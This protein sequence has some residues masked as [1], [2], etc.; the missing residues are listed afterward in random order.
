M[1]RFGFQARLLMAFAAAIAI[2]FSLALATWYVISISSREAGRITVTHELLLN[3][4]MTRSYMF[5]AEL[6]TQTYRITG[7]PVHLK[8]RDQAA[9][10]RERALARIRQLIVDDQVLLQFFVSLREL[11]DQRLAI[12][13]QVEKIRQQGGESAATAFIATAPL[14]ETRIKTYQLLDAMEQ[15]QRQILQDRENTYQR[16]RKTLGWIEI[17]LAISFAMVLL[18]AYV[19]LMRQV[20]RMTDTQQ[21]LSA[22]EESLTATMNSIGDA[23][24]VTDMEGMITRFNPVAERLTGWPQLQAR[25]TRFNEVICIVDEHSGQPVAVNL[26]ELMTRGSYAS[27]QSHLRIVSRQGCE[28]PVADCVTLLTNRNGNVIGTVL[29][30]RDVSQLRLNERTLAEKNSHLEQDVQQKALALTEKESHLQHVMAAVPVLI[31]FVGADQRYIYVNHQYRER[32]APHLADLSGMRVDQVLGPDLYEIACPLIDRALAGE[33]VSYDWQPFPGV[34]QAIRYLPRFD[35]QGKVTGYFV[36][37]TDIT[38]RKISEDRIGRLN[39][40]LGERVRE[41]E[42]VSRA[43]RTLSAGNRAMLHARNEQDLL[44]AMCE[45]IV[46]TCGYSTAIVWYRTSGN[47]F[48]LQPEAHCGYLGDHQSL[49]ALGLKLSRRGLGEGITAAAVQ[50]GGSH[51]ARGMQSDPVHAA[52]W[53]QLNKPVCGLACPLI[54]NQQVIGSLT[55]YDVQPDA[56]PQQE[57]GL[58]NELADDLSFGIATLRAGI[59]Q[60]RVQSEM[61]YL[62]RYDKLTGLPNALAF[63][64]AIQTTIERCRADQTCFSAQQL[65]IERLGEINEVLGYANGDLIL[66]EFAQRLRELAPPPAF[67]A[68]LRG[69]EFGVLR[70]VSDTDHALS[71]AEKMMQDLRKPYPVADITID[72]GAKTGVAVFPLHGNS[73]DELLRRTGKA[74]YRAR[75]YGHEVD[76]YRESSQQDQLERLNMAGELRRAIDS[77]QLRF[78]LQPKIDMKTGAVAG[79]EALMRWLHPRRGLVPPGQFIGLAEQ[80]GL[81]KPLTEWLIVAVLDMLKAWQEKGLMIPVAINLSAR[82]FRDQQLL[83]KIRRWNDERQVQRGLLEVE[84]TESTVMDDPEY[85]MQVLRSLKSDG[86]PLYVDDFGTGYSSLSYLQKLP[87]DYIKIDQSFVAAMLSNRDSAI[88]VKS[89]I[90][91]IHDLGHKTIAEGVE[92]IEHWDRLAALGC[93]Y[94][95][96]YLIARPMPVDEFPGWLADYRPQQWFAASEQAG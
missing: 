57:V 63:A 68:R 30:F 39:H 42:L 64:E 45:T 93:D 23:V 86:I 24:V 36:L 4:A 44:Q 17:S 5:Q 90:D 56:F 25:G 22:S 71:A 27:S 11:T 9:A 73:V 52:W 3:L 85:A 95:Q 75:T 67:V 34:W 15:E 1:R 59:E 51:L 20:R 77:G 28:T 94:A 2:V 61:E 80:T 69:D 38:E 32:F 29:A 37:G 40:E 74:L 41:L 33:S 70:P 7:D 26:Q 21:A 84:V 48:G 89:T 53:D 81:L 60:Q 31:A 35:Q 92:T 49:F 82:N 76:I 13:R 55:I 47:E 14:R 16:L 10:D 62:L 88:I 18:A 43:L 54:V 19:Q 91:L 50:G 65:N 58:L 78:F 72:I 6:A 46:R 96:G 79:A 66:Q 87:F 8:E 83:E 12:S